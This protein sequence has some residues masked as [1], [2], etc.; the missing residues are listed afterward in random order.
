MKI[1]SFERLIAF[2]ARLVILLGVNLLITSSPIAGQSAGPTPTACPVQI[3]RDS[4]SAPPTVF[5][6]VENHPLVPWETLAHFQYDIPDWDDKQKPKSRL[7]NKKFPIPDFIQRLN[8]TNVAVVGFMI[9]LDT[10]GQG[11]RVFSFILAMSRASC[12]YGIVPKMNEWMF[13]Q[14]EKGKDADDT[15]DVPV[16]VFGT[17]EVGEEIA[18][19]QGWSLY[20]MVSDKVV[21][22]K[23]NII[24]EYK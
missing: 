1:K 24:W 2:S 15:M 6:Q 9:P 19:H 13:I 11:D 4:K 10:N 22:Q 23:Q 3:G 21:V 8:G 5:S 12:C 14:M 17:F 7:K 18:K 20:R 16:T